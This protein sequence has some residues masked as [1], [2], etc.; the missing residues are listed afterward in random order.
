MNWLF[1]PI[2]TKHKH[3]DSESYPYT[4]SFGC[5]FLNDIIKGE[6]VIVGFI[7][8]NGFWC[9]GKSKVTFQC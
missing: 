3:A 8:E 7:G 9:Q 2:S 6:L 4:A 1:P 5:M